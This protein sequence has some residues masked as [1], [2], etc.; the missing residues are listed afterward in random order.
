MND[1]ENELRRY[2]VA[3]VANF[4]D[5]SGEV[6]TAFAVAEYSSPYRWLLSDFHD[7]AEA[8]QNDIAE[9]ARCIVEWRRD[10]AARQARIEAELARC[11]QPDEMLRA[12]EVGRAI[13]GGHRVR[14]KTLHD[15]EDV[16]RA[17]VSSEPLPHI[18][19]YGCGGARLGDDCVHALYRL[20]WLARPKAV[21]FSDMYNS[22]LFTIV[23]RCR[24]FAVLVESWK[25]EPALRYLCVE[26]ALF[27]A[28]DEI[29]W[30]VVAGAPEKD[31][32]VRCK[33]DAGVAFF[34]FVRLCATT[35]HEVYPG[36]NFKV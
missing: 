6:R 8:A 24:R 29:G 21:D 36:N 28:N 7:T 19:F 18:P 9:R 30:R 14:D 23:S 3:E 32:G 34:E 13:L 4:T 22:N 2:T 33:D 27:D 31:N 26:S 11:A 12:L 25:C 1:Y 10:E 16:W 35:P 20:L 15:I 17:V 5:D